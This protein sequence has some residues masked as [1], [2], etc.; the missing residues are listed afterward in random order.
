MKI[1]E[2]GLILEFISSISDIISFLSISKSFYSTKSTTPLLYAKFAIN[3]G[4]LRNKNWMTLFDILNEIKRISHLEF[5]CYLLDI[6]ST[7][8]MYK[9]FPCCFK[10]NTDLLSTLSQSKI[11]M[12]IEQ[13]D[14]NEDDEDNDN[15]NSLF[16]SRTL[17]ISLNYGLSKHSYIF[18]AF[19][20]GRNYINSENNE[21]IEEEVIGG[22]SYQLHIALLNENSLNEKEDLQFCLQSDLCSMCDK[23]RCVLCY[24]V[25]LCELCDEKYCST[26][27]TCNYCDCCDMKQC[28]NCSEFLICSNKLCETYCCNHCNDHHG[29]MTTCEVCDKSYCEG[30][31]DNNQISFCENCEEWLCSL[32][33]VFQ[34]CDACDLALCSRCHAF[35]K[36]NICKA[37]YCEDCLH[38]KVCENCKKSDCETDCYRYSL[39]AAKCSKCGD[40]SCF[41]CLPFF[42]CKICKDITCL[43][44]QISMCT[45]CKDY[46]CLDC[47]LMTICL[48]PSCRTKICNECYSKNPSEHCS[49]CNCYLFHPPTSISCKQS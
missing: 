25:S 31:L 14:N 40:I 33:C 13:N 41:D 38:I 42:T 28:S 34:Q 22:G 16:D 18:D 7:F 4:I 15:N 35:I 9:N 49:Q 10:L 47:Q 36:C 2:I 19:P 44:C 6:K 26:C 21:Q 48:N 37:T 23:Y 5:P 39:L 43:E 29:F 27:C 24:D 8:L 45:V 30:C 32:C 17:K 20:L 1:I 12:I 46:V 3:L 11:S